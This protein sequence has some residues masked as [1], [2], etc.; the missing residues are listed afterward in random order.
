MQAA[1][2]TTERQSDASEKRMASEIE[3]CFQWVPDDRALL[4][5]NDNISGK[6]WKMFFRRLGLTDTDIYTIEYRTS[7]LKE[8]T[9]QLLC[10][11]REVQGAQA[12]FRQLKNAALRNEQKDLANKIEGIATGSE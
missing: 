4:A 2:D 7:D 10:K 8:Q 6:R 9:W 3:D 11:W 1:T 5:V 12:T